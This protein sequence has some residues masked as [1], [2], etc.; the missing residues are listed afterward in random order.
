MIE[1]RLLYSGVMRRLLLL[2]CLAFAL[3]APAA[4]KCWTN[5][6]GVRE[7]G[8]VVPAEYAQKGHEVKSEQGLTLS[9]QPPART[10]EEIARERESRAAAEAAAAKANAA[11][12]QQRVADRMLLDTFG[13]EAD[14]L[15]ARDGQ[16]QNVESQ[17]KL[18]E[19]L[20]AKLEKSLGDMISRAAQFERRKQTL[21]EDLS[22]NV[23]S[24]QDQIAEQRRFIAEK[25]D[26][27]DAL[28]AKFERDLARLRE[29]RGE[30]APEVSD[31]R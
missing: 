16:I 24:T 22:R 29:L 23:Q 2:T 18:A 19:S 4:I 31:A 20:I 3:P 15:L 14:L 9:R 6:D 21:P 13:S 10:P 26:E 5:Q 1:P 7:C 8:D 25:R 30:A 27:Q 12:E 17:I 28:R 11:A